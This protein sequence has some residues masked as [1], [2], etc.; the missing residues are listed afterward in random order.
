M[1]KEILKFLQEKGK[2]TTKELVE[3][4]KKDRTTIYRWLKKLEDAGK[5]EVLKKGTYQIKESLE[6]YFST[7]T[8]ERKKANYNPDFLRNYKPNKTYFF[9]ENNLQKLQNSTLDLPID[10]DFYKTNKR[11]LETLLIDLTFASSYLEGNTYS[12]LDTEVLLKYNEINKEKTQEE[13]QMILNHKKAIEYMIY[14]KKDLDFNKNT[15]SEIHTLLGDKLLLKNDLGIIRNKIVEIG[16]STYTPLENKYRL[17]EEFEL[18]LE[19]LNLIKN[20]FEQS[21]FIM[22][23]IPYFQ[24]FLD[25]NKRTSRIMCN[26]PL[27]KNNLPVLSLIQLEKKKYI[28][29]ILSVYELNNF[30]LLQNIWTENYLLNLEKYKKYF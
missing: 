13:T 18:F 8:W 16:G 27:I 20:P 15:F 19:K 25:I 5:I 23:F 14:Y 12:Y 4:F 2:V 9:S 21:L 11:F 7:P 29:G 3:Y 28:I 10:T 30:D 17:E 22:V 6:Q 26:L 24:L 1:E